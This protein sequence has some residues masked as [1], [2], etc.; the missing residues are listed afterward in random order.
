MGIRRRIGLLSY[1]GNTRES[2]NI[3]KRFSRSLSD[4]INNGGWITCCIL[5]FIGLVLS[6]TGMGMSLINL[7]KEDLTSFFICLV[8]DLIVLGVAVFG[9][10]G[11]I[12]I[13][14]NNKD[15]FK[16]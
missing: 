6:L 11:I 13:I 7:A 1:F 9:I 14:K 8:V 15:I 3:F 2:M 4:W 5:G 16:L 12:R 10:S